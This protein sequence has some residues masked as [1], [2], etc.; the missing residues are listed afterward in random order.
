MPEATWSCHAD[1]HLWNHNTWWVKLTRML[2][3]L[4]F[5]YV[6]QVGI[7]E[8]AADREVGSSLAGDGERGDKGKSLCMCGLCCRTGGQFGLTKHHVHL[9]LSAQCVWQQIPWAGTLGLTGSPCGRDTQTA[10]SHLQ[11]GRRTGLGIVRQALHDRAYWESQICRGWKGPLE[12]ICSNSPLQQFPI[13]GCTGRF[14][15][16]PEETTQP[17]WA[18]CSSAPSPSR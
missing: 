17:V 13:A 2:S 12:I 4:S 6:F 5:P 10:L 15:V 8:W 11:L 18:A 16:S 14:W 1:F 3:I 9:K 7:S